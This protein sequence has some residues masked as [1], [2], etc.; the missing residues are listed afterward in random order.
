MWLVNLAFSVKQSYIAN[1][2]CQNKDKPQMQCKGK[3]YLE[4]QLQ[5]S[6]QNTRH[7]TALLKEVNLDVFGSIQ[8]LQLKQIPAQFIPALSYPTNQPLL[9]SGFMAAI[10]HPPPAQHT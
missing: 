10:F 3:C 8:Q 6:E 2:L 9:T 5:Q 4:K 1:T 7:N